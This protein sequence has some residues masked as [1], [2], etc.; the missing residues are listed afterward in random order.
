[1]KK[2]F[3]R[4]VKIGLMALISILILYFGI[5]YLKGVNVF[6][7]TNYYYATYDNIDGLVETNPVMIRGYQ[8]GMVREIKRD[9][10][11]QKPFVVVLYIDKGLKLPKGTKA[12]LFDNGLMGGKAVQ[13]VFD[14]SATAY[15]EAGDTLVSTVSVG[16]MGQ[17]S[18]DLMPKINSLITETDSLIVAVRTVVQSPELKKS[19]SSIEKTTAELE[20]SSTELKKIMKKDLPKVIT[21]VNVITSNLAIVSNNIKKIDFAST[22][23]SVD[24]TIANLNEVT[25]KMNSK[26]GSL[27]LLIND[28]RLYDNLNDISQN[29]NILVVDLKQNPKRYVHFSV[30]A[31]K[32]KK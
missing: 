25:R 15:Q 24:N 13:L 2:L 14:P 23:A 26:E 12:D 6:K 1:M 31:P 10:S 28:T 32:D 18:A 17:L 3:T 19:L 11:K 22:M 21:D 30:F 29:A 4:E 16:L 8:V 27:G 20:Q 9:F 5:N 7:P